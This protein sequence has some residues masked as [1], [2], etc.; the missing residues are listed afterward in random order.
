MVYDYDHIPK[1]NII[2]FLAE[3]S[4]SAQK[5]KQDIIVGCSR[6]NDC[7]KMINYENVELPKLLL[8]VPFAFLLF[9]AIYNRLLGVRLA[10]SH[11]TLYLINVKLTQRAS[12]SIIVAVSVYIVFQAKPNKL[13]R[14]V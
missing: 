12:K 8:S 1:R 7:Y 5:C 13:L 11:I 10:N 2:I 14:I 3:K 9:L 6:R 4:L